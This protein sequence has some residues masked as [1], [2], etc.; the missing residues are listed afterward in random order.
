M[1]HEAP[2]N[3]PYFVARLDAN[4]VIVVVLRRNMSKERADRLLVG[5]P[6]GYV[7]LNELELEQLPPPEDTKA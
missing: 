2:A 3:G 5:L 7:R 6:S 4:G 1:K